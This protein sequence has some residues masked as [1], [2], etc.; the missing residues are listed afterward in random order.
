M[1]IP[2]NPESNYPRQG[3]TGQTGAPTRPPGAYLDYIS[4]AFNIVKSNAG[5]YV[6][7]T[8]LIIVASWVIQFGFSLIISLVMGTSMSNGQPTGANIG[9]TLLLMLIMIVPNAIVQMLIYGLSAAAVE[10]LDTG[11]TSLNTVFG[12]LKNG[13]NLFLTLLL[14]TMAIYA[15]FLLCIIPGFFVAGALWMAPS[16]CIQENLGPIDA[17]KKSWDV[18]KPRAFPLF[19]VMFVCGLVNIIGLIA[20]GV[21]L[22]WTIPIIYVVQAMHYRDHRNS[23]FTIS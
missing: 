10:Q 6:V 15:G 22:L 2:P 23:T 19:G 3:F 5:V 14:M 1:D 17:L 8:L 20:C 13:V 11:A 16:F 4:D 7:G 12:V 18:S 9:A 21:G